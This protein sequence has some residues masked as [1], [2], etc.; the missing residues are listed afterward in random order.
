MLNFPLWEEGGQSQ[1][2][3][4]LVSMHMIQNGSGQHFKPLAA[5]SSDWEVVSCQSGAQLSFLLIPQLQYNFSFLSQVEIFMWFPLKGQG[6]L[7]SLRPLYLTSRFFATLAELPN[8][9]LTPTSHRKQALWRR[10][11]CVCGGTPQNL[12]P[13]D[14]GNHIIY[15]YLYVPRFFDYY[16]HFPWNYGYKIRF[17]TTILNDM[18][19]DFT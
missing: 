6:Y 14:N 8:F 3:I 19:T 16:K 18:N 15:P 11:V 13:L 17:P 2:I 12:E 7:L 1:L 10:T 9:I 4:E 5:V